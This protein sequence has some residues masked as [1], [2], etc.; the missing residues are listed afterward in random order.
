M[1]QGL[2]RVPDAIEPLI[3]YRAWSFVLDP[4]RASLFPI[5]MRRDLEAPSPWDGAHRDWVSA[6]CGGFAPHLSD[7]MSP[8]HDVPDEGCACGFYATKTLAVFLGSWLFRRDCILGRVELAG[9][10]IEC[11]AGYRAQRARI[12]ELIP[13]RGTEPAAIRLARRLRLPLRASIPFAPRPERGPS[14]A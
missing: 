14:A 11:T 9:K 10:V 13:L 6:S 7:D 2:E 12:V 5:M 3:G 1:M 4:R 8:R